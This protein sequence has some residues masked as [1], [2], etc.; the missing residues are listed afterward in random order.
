MRRQTFSPLAF[1]LPHLFLQQIQLL[2]YRLLGQ[3][4][5]GF[6]FQGVEL[7]VRFVD[8]RRGTRQVAALAGRLV[9]GREALILP[10]GIDELVSDHAD[11]ALE[12]GQPFPVLGA[13]LL[14]DPGGFR[15]PDLGGEAAAPLG[16]G[17]MLA[18]QGQLT[19]RRGEGVAVHPD[20]DL[21]LDERCVQAGR[22]GATIIGESLTGE[23]AIEAG[24]QFV[25]THRQADVGIE[26]YSGVVSLGIRPA[27][28][29]SRRA[30]MM[31][32][33][34][35]LI[36]ALLPALVLG[37]S[38]KGSGYGCGVATVA[39]QSLLLEEFTRPGATLSTPPARLPSGL[40]VR[41]ALGPAY[42]SVVGRTDTLL[43]VGVQGA[44]P[45]E[46]RV[47]FGVLIVSPADSALGVLLYDGSPIQG[48]PQ[49]GTVNAGYQNFPLIGLRL[50]VSKFQNPS[51][52]IFPDSLR[53]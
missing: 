49:L 46:S 12:E 19:F 42:R 7:A 22:A 28:T 26:C 43:I 13:E 6:G 47:G 52:P 3:L 1:P 41:V 18:L 39:G 51:C 37:C 23:Q 5:V 2:F 53:Q 35:A 31:P 4:A 8:Q 40:P 33:R 50:D 30:S 15:I 17:E 44:L 32:P 24:A 10:L 36:A 21:E 25:E 38:Q 11:F 48:A 9:L 20:G 16:I 45:S 29:P 14:G 27:P 34:L